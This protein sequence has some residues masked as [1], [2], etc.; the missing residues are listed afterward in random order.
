MV[1]YDSRKIPCCHYI[2]REV[3]YDINYVPLLPFMN[4]KTHRVC[5]SQ[6]FQ[7]G[8][9]AQLSIFHSSQVSVSHT[10]LYFTSFS[11]LYLSLTLPLKTYYYH[12]DA[13]TQNDLRKDLLWC[14]LVMNQD[15][16]QHWHSRNTLSCWLSNSNQNCLH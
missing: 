12:N 13:L 14:S 9:R 11:I 16:W 5:F 10:S 4:M 8:I 7:Q 2:I 1:G 15:P 6:N 3:T